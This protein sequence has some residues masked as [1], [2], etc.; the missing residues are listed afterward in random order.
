[1]IIFL[2]EVQN[3]RRAVPWAGLRLARNRPAKR[4]KVG[5]KLRQT[6]AL[7]I[8]GMMNGRYRSRVHDPVVGKEAVSRCLA[9]WCRAHPTAKDLQD[10]LEDKGTHPKSICSVRA[11]HQQDKPALVR[12]EGTPPLRSLWKGLTQN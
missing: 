1:M 11:I 7:L 2:Q 9:G 12:G 5:L 4:T 3:D 10:E 6:A 8:L